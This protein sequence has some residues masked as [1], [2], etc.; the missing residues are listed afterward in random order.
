[1]DGGIFQQAAE[2]LI[3]LISGQFGLSGRKKGFT[4]DSICYEE[5]M[6]QSMSANLWFPRS[7]LLC[8]VR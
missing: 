1:M 8:V 3:D 5:F 2:M 4:F 7:D 6:V